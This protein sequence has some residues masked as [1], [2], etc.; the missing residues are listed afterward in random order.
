MGTVLTHRLV[1]NPSGVPDPNAQFPQERWFID[2]KASESRDTV[3]F[4]LA[5]KFDLAGQKLPS[6]RSSPTSA[7][8]LQV[9]GVRLQPF[10]RP[11]QNNRRH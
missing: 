4:E 8:G 3:T 9:N 5:S 6:V 7:S 11:R 2:R 1:G 10:Y